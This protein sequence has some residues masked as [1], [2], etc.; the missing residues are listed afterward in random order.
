MKRHRTIVSTLVPIGL[1]CACAPAAALGHGPLLS[2]YGGPGSGTQVILGSALING[3]GG[4]AGGRGSQGEA[5]S[6][7]AG[8]S[9]SAG[10]LP[11]GSNG[12]SATHAAN[13]TQEHGRG[14]GSRTRA[15][16]TSGRATTNPSRAAGATPPISDSEDASATSASWF[17][18]AD[19]LAVALA[20][21]TLLLVG[22][23]TMRLARTEHH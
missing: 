10:S 21:A 1:L 9:Q 22:L 15:G 5:G 23:A 17:S 7:G 2:G 12:S 11:A 16:R 8:S 3:G 20:A 4:G 18:G 19:T 6:Q 13:G 14:G